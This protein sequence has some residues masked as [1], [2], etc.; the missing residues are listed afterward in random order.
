LQTTEKVGKKVFPKQQLKANEIKPQL[1]KKKELDDITA[2]TL[3]KVID[4]VDDKL[5]LER[6][7]SF[8][9]RQFKEQIY[10]TLIEVLE[11]SGRH[12]SQSEKQ[13][14]IQFVFDEIFGFG[15]INSLLNDPT[16]SEIMVNGWDN[17]Y[18]E[19]N[20]KLTKT[21][22]TFRDNDHVLH[23]INKIITPLGRRIDESSPS[24]DARM[25]D[26]SR[27]NAIIPPLSLKG[28][29]ITIRKFSADPFTVD[30]L[31]ELGTMSRD[32]ARF[33]E[34][35]VRSRVNI[36]VSGGTGSGKT[37]TLNVLSGFIPD[38]ER[39]ITI[40]DTAELQLRQDN[41]VTLESR[42]ANIEGRG[43]YTIREL[44]INSL[45]MRPDR[46]VVGEVRGAE[47]LDMLQAMNTGHDGSISTL[48]ANNP[49]DAL[50]RLETMVLMA[51]MELPLRVVREQI[52]S[53]VELIIQ[54]SRFSDGTRRITR[55]SEVAGMKKDEIFLQ[56]I[57][58][59]KQSEIDE[60]GR[61]IGEHIPTGVYPKCMD[62][63]NS[64]GESS[65]VESI[66][67]KISDYKE[68]EAG[69]SE[70]FEEDFQEE[71]Q[72]QSYQD[73]NQPQLYQDEEP[74][75]ELQPTGS[76]SD[77]YPDVAGGEEP[78]EDEEDDEVDEGDEEFTG[79]IT[80]ELAGDTVLLEEEDARE[81]HLLDEE[82]PAGYQDT[83]NKETS[84]GEE[85]DQEPA[86]DDYLLE[87][88]SV[89]SSSR[90]YGETSEQIKGSVISLNSFREG[91][92]P[93]VDY[94]PV[95]EQ[96][97]EVEPG[98]GVEQSSG[99]EPDPD[100]KPVHDIESVPDAG[101]TAEV[102]PADIEPPEV[103]RSSSL[104]SRL[105]QSMRGISIPLN[106]GSGLFD[107][108]NAG[109][110]VDV[111][112]IYADKNDS[113]ELPAARTAAQ[114]AL[115][116][117]IRET[118]CENNVELKRPAAAAILAVTLKQAEVLAY[119]CLKGSFH[120]TLRPGSNTT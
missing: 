61:I 57:F 110:R 98:L 73:E 23:V 6:L 12:L 79:V 78:A 96:I 26:G 31:I 75:L 1:L 104:S 30:D 106:T 22:V 38:D 29:S 7:D 66:L 13:K 107:F 2:E 35:C 49:R 63:L 103:K 118:C 102:A 60:D 43:Q 9:K 54:Q 48:H 4:S 90:A 84:P 41:I 95:D 45:R 39:I 74:D 42:P 53:A 36:I 89:T 83:E 117:E 3:T 21:D 51:G 25:P 88:V 105:P 101:Y 68:E 100:V 91:Y 40:E 37:T 11:E 111:L 92:A 20:G 34:A 80:E 81:H 67:E 59:F 108:I 50:S 5:V 8:Q 113:G 97:L 44:V 114:D 72:P 65:V 19:R 70:L 56:D 76:G 85:N 120:L 47:A 28:P 71:N 18:V 24:V 99:I 77:P 82:L 94:R 119:A 52:N 112:V 58:V 64:C 69:D 93:P 14:V 86:D 55:I 10:D 15:P 32:M 116:L 87:P 62:K 33:L 46:I 16:V 115:V 27:V 17:V 109:D